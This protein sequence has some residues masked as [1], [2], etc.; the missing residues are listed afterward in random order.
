M[1]TADLWPAI[2]LQSPR[3][4]AWG[5]L[6]PTNR[7]PVLQLR[8]PHSETVVLGSCPWLCHSIKRNGVTCGGR[9][10][11][12]GLGGSQGLSHSL[13]QLLAQT[14]APQDPRQAPF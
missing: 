4:P 1:V 13:D 7:V 11:R 5:L 14:R 10:G 9:Q 6:Q 12:P 3:A 2:S 8:F